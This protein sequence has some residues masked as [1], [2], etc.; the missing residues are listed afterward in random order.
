MN[1]ILNALTSKTI[2]SLLVSLAAG[3]TAKYGIGVEELN[4]GVQLASEVIQ[5]G[6]LVAAGISRVIAQKNLRTGASLSRGNPVPI[7]YPT[8]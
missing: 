3:I 6:A 4:H 1:L 8:P 5:Y 7:E 2:L